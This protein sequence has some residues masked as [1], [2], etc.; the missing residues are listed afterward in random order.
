MFEP[1]HRNSDISDSLLEVIPS[2]K[3]S[4][5]TDEGRVAFIGYYYCNAVML[6]AF[7]RNFIQS[8]KP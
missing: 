6:W 3:E 5:Q 8:D 1:L 7:L 4:E 2:G